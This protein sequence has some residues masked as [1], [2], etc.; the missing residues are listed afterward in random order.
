M[1]NLM[2]DLQVVVF[3]NDLL[4]MGRSEKEH[5]D[6][7]QKVL[8]RLQENGLWLQRSK[9]ELSKTQVE[10]LGNILDEQ[11]IHPSKDNVKALQE[12]PALTNM[13]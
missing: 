2:K 8:Q 7:L 1:E 12:A 13:K 11:G 4:I 3:L 9:C 10:H 6:N 5:L